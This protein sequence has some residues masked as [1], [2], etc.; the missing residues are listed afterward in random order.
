MAFAACPS[1]GRR[2]RDLLCWAPTPA[3][4]ST[5][6]LSERGARVL[7]GLP[8]RMRKIRVRV[9][10]MLRL[11]P[12]PRNA[13]GGMPEQLKIAGKNPRKPA[14]DRRPKCTRKNASSRQG[15]AA[16]V[17]CLILSCPS[18][19][20]PPVR[21]YALLPLLAMLPRQSPQTTTNAHGRL[22]VPG[23]KQRKY[24]DWMRLDPFRGAFA[25]ASTGC[26]HF[27]VDAPPIC[28]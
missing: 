21:S 10:V 13:T 15:L 17:Q 11:S 9:R 18:P 5:K 25:P 1:A 26:R 14:H 22:S 7:R 2:K 12:L 4:W 27:A 20:P 28:W 3:P 23:R 8:G 24:R 19:F 6:G 16:F